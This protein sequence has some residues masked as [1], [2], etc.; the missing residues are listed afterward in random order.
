MAGIFRKRKPLDDDDY[1]ND[2]SRSFNKQSK[3][4]SWNERVETQESNEMIRYSKL[5][6]N[7]LDVICADVKEIKEQMV[8]ISTPLDFGKEGKIS[9]NEEFTF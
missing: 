8:T 1:D 9:K 2:G 4:G 6:V 5:M 3:S 7:K